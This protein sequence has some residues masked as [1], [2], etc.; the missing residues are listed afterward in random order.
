MS[1]QTL[2]V[3]R[4]L[5][6]A[7]VFS[8]MFP[9]HLRTHFLAVPQTKRLPTQIRGNLKLSSSNH[10]HSVLHQVQ[11][12][13]EQVEVVHLYHLPNQTLRVLL[14]KS[15]LQLMRIL[16][17]QIYQKRSLSQYLNKHSRHLIQ[18]VDLVVKVVSSSVQQDSKL[19]LSHQPLRLARS[20]L[21]KVSVLEEACLLLNRTSLPLISLQKIS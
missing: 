12:Y 2:Q 13:L 18:E 3:H 5:L 4:P 1:S 8:Q 7:A 10:L 6:L 11:D 20:H 15:N 19:K 9:V 14:R 17:Q 16:M 21:R